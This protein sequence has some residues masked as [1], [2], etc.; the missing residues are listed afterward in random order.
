MAVLDGLN[1]ESVA[2][3]NVR[4]EK[5]SDIP[6]VSFSGITKRVSSKIPAERDI[7]S[8]INSIGIG[9]GEKIPAPKP[10][11]AGFD[12]FGGREPA[13]LNDAEDEDSQGDTNEFTFS[14]ADPE[15]MNQ[16]EEPVPPVKSQPE[17]FIHNEPEDPDDIIA[18]ILRDNNRN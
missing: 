2:K 17:Q 15:E 18:Q 5:A 11:P 7:L 9:A 13:E 14:F 4:E 3:Q 6:S 16:A 1:N 10:E 12:I 8:E